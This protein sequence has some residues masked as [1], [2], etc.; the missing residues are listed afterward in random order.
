MLYVHYYIYVELLIPLPEA[1][2][3]LGI[4]HTINKCFEIREIIDILI[5][6]G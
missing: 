2:C 5:A 3:C 4:P 6:L 1:H